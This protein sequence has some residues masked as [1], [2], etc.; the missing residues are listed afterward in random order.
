MFKD[1]QCCNGGSDLLYQ[2]VDSTAATIDFLLSAT[3]DAVAAKWFS[4]ESIEFAGH[5]AGGHGLWL[6]VA[7]RFSPAL[8]RYRA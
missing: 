8:Q 3:R 5:P 4:P 1:R 2:T 6:A 7:G